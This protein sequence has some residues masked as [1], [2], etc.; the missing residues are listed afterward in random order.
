M[1]EKTARVMCKIKHY[2][3]HGTF[4]ITVPKSVIE[5]LRLQKEDSVIVTITPAFRPSTEE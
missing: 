5:E 1:E 3:S 2:Q 4:T